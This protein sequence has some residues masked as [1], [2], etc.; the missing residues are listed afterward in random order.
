MVIRKITLTFGVVYVL[1][2]VE[3]T[4]RVDNLTFRPIPVKKILQYWRRSKFVIDLI[5]VFVNSARFINK[6]TTK[7]YI[8]Q[9]P[10]FRSCVRD[11]HLGNNILWNSRP[12]S[13]L[14]YV[15]ILLL[16]CLTPAPL[17][18]RTNRYKSLKQKVIF[19]SKISFYLTQGTVIK[20]D[21][22]YFYFLFNN[23]NWSLNYNFFFYIYKTTNLKLTLLTGN[24]HKTIL[25]EGCLKK[26][27]KRVCYSLSRNWCFKQV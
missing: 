5:K 10:T 9:P 8:V 24:H 6:N 11:I 26:P 2:T 18:N 1:H 22:P 21:L 25:Q 27:G 16:F 17:T 4:R 14:L 23:P 3:E 20:I 19:F 12:F 13:V 15:Y 7:G